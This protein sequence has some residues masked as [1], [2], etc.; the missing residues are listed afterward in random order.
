MDKVNWL[1]VIQ[2]L[3]DAKEELEKLERK[4]SSQDY[5]DEIEF[6]IALQHI[7]HHLDFAWN[8]RNISPDEYAGLEPTDFDRLGKFPEDLYLG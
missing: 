5:P 2:D 3:M 4:V 8:T 7:F 1:I 6:R